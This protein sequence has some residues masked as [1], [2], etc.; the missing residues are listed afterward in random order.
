MVLRTGGPAARW[1]V[2]LAL[3]AGLCPAPAVAQTLFQWPDTAMVVAHYTTIEECLAAVDRIRERVRQAGISGGVWLDTM[4][5]DPRRPLDP[6]PQVV[7]T[8]AAQCA[9][10]FTEA[11]SDLRDYEELLQLFLEADRDTDAAALV[12]RRLS[13]ATTVGAR[14]VVLDTAVSAYLNAEPVRLKAA[15]A[16]L[17]AQTRTLHDPIEELSLYGR[18]MFRELLVDDTVRAQGTAQQL[19]TVYAGLTP[20]EREQVQSLYDGFGKL[21]MLMG[22]YAYIGNRTILDSLR[23]G[24]GAY[25]RLIDSVWV[26]TTGQQPAA[27]E[28]PLGERAPTVAGNFWFPADS[29]QAAQPTPGRVTLVAFLNRQFTTVADPA[30]PWGTDL[31][32]QLAA[33]R[34]L[35][36]RFPAL[37]IILLAQTRGYFWYDTM[38]SPGV[39]A[40]WVHRAVEA[41]KLPPGALLAVSSTPFFRL[42]APDEKRVNQ[43]VVNDTSYAFGRTPVGDSQSGWGPEFLVD[44]NGIVVGV[45]GGLEPLG[46]RI[47]LDPM[48]DA[49]LHRQGAARIAAPPTK[50]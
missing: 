47:P 26:K 14:E 42:P 44:Q 27:M 13:A 2:V 37:Q 3:V 36:R 29:A 23:Q 20:T 39:E 19:L 16:L 32:A 34:R 49:L 21:L 40:D 31:L 1:F 17:Q 28:L 5:P 18:L 22:T 11:A 24:T 43:M 8:T 45:G 9:A 41:Q 33:L 30:V 10:Q 15:E 48:I 6:A 25:L 46:I 7:T 35:A 50:S 4:P 12:S 38:P